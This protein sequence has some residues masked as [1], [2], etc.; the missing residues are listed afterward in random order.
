MS[1]TA[2]AAFVS[3]RLSIRWLP[4]E[5]SE[6]THTIVLTGVRRGIFLDVRFFKGTKELDWAFAGYRTTD[7]NN[8]NVIKFRHDIDSRTLESVEDSGTNTTLPDGTTLEIGEMIDPR[9]GKI[10]PFEEIWRDRE[11]GDPGSVLFIRNVS[12]TIWQARVGRWQ[13]GLGRRRDGVF[14]A[15]QAERDHESKWKIKHS[16]EGVATDEVV[17][18]PESGKIKEWLEGS[19]V[20]WLGDEWI[21]L[22]RGLG[23]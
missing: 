1:S 5:A 4:E 14:W 23:V 19:T 13:M 3:F 8:P 17:W 11:E 18:L 22:E 6:P 15:W 10:T 9:T 21:V 7:P 12:G 2:P 20:M 16:T